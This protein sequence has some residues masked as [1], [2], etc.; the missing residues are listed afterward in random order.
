MS[1][2]SSR[3]NAEASKLPQVFLCKINLT[4]QYF[5]GILF[6]VR[7]GDN[8]NSDGQAVKI[9]KS[10]YAR[11]KKLASK[12]GRFIKAVLDKAVESYLNRKKA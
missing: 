11:L 3:K 1:L 10:L 9:D 2:C 5:G 7:G 4:T 8:V 12:E 6:I